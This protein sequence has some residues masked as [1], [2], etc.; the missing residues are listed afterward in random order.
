M[1]KMRILLACFIAACSAV[2]LASPAAAQEPDCSGWPW[3]YTWI[4]PPPGEGAIVELGDGTVTVRGGVAIAQATA[5]VDYYRSH[6]ATFVACT[7][8]VA[9][10]VSSPVTDCI[11]AEAAPVFSD[12][13]PIGRY[14]HVG[15]DLSVTIDYGRLLDDVIGIA[16]CNGIVTYGG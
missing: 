16:N 12:P 9:E 15:A 8:E 14:L 1:R 7:Q 10:G 11:A 4:V 2:P 5:L 3:V 13:D 6:L